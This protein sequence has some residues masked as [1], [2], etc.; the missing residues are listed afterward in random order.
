MA[1]RIKSTNNYLKLNISECCLRPHSVT[2]SYV[3]FQSPEERS[4]YND[5][6]KMLDSFRE[7]WEKYDLNESGR[8]GELAHQ[9]GVTDDPF[10]DSEIK[11]HM[12]ELMEIHNDVMEVVRH[13]DSYG[14]ELNIKNLENL[15]RFGFDLELLQKRIY[16]QSCGCDV[17]P[18]SGQNF[19]YECMY[20]ELK[21]L[22]PNDYEDC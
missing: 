12:D 8:I 18:Y 2:V 15:T 9:K 14:Y 22:F 10:S 11:K 13:W 20:E 19:S 3:L 1:I 7:K 5:C 4:E 16:P 21:K 17:G 6:C